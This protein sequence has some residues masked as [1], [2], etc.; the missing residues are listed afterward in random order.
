MGGV[1]VGD[2]TSLRPKG[3]TPKIVGGD[4]RKIPTE[5]DEDA[6]MERYLR[7]ELRLL[8][9]KLVA[10]LGPEKAITML[11]REV[12]VIYGIADDQREDT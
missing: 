6:R 10:I 12:G 7:S 3:W 9:Q 2:V 5:G 11:D 8:R 1:P 4:I